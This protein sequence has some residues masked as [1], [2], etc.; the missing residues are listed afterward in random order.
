MG[1]TA[2]CGNNR[3]EVTA[4]NVVGVARFSATALPL[5]ADQ[6]NVGSGNDQRV[7]T[8]GVAP[9]P[10]SAWVSDSNNPIEGVPVTF[11]VREGGG[12]VNGLES[13][14]VPTRATGHA[15]VT[16]TA[17]PD[18]GINRVE[19][20][21]AGNRG[22][23]AVFTTYGIA[24][25][26]S[27]P[28]SFRGLVLDNSNRTIGRVKVTLKFGTTLVGPRLTNDEGQ[29]EFTDL[30]NDGAVH[31][32]VEG[33]T[34][35]KLG[36]QPIPAGMRFPSL[37]YD[38]AI[39]PNAENTLGKPIL[40][41]PLL[42]ENSVMWDGQSDV[43]LTCAGL[44]G[45]RFKVKAG[46]MTLENGSH[47]TPTAPVRLS[48]NQVHHDDVPMPMPNGVAPP[49]AWTFQPASATF[50]PPVEI[51]YP[52]MSAL[53][54]GAT[55]Y[56]LTFNHDLGE[57]E[58][59]APGRV[60]EDG[61][62]IV[63]EPGA[64][65]RL[66][67]WGCNC[68]PYSFNGSA[69]CCEPTS[70]GCGP[71]GNPLLSFLI[72]D[73]LVSQLG[74]VYC[75]TPACDNH[76]YCWGSCST[77]PGHKDACDQDILLDM[78]EICEQMFFPFECRLASYAYYT[79]VSRF[80]SG[81]YA[82][83]QSQL[84]KAGCC[85]G[86][87]G[88]AGEGGS[89]PSPPFPDA[90]QDGLP[91]DWEVTH[92]LSPE[93]PTD[94]FQDQDFDGLI[95]LMEFATQ[96]DPRAQ[97]SD[98]DG[99]MDGAQVAAAQ[100][101][102]KVVPDETWTYSLS[103][104]S[105]E[106][107]GSGMFTFLNVNVVDLEADLVSDDPQRIVGTGV[108][109]GKTY[110][111]VSPPIY[112]RAG[113]TSQIAP[114]T[115][116]AT[117]PLV[118]S[119]IVL[120]ASSNAL[121]IGAMMPLTTRALQS[122]G[123]VV[124]V[125][126]A[127]SFT[128]YRTSN[129]ALATVS[130][131]GVVTGIGTGRVFIT[132]KN[133][134]A[135]AVRQID[136]VA[137]AF[138]TIVTGTVQLPSGA[139]A[140]GASLT[141]SLGGKVTTSA[142]G[143]YELPL[144]V[145]TGQSSIVISAAVEV[146]G[147][148]FTGSSSVTSL[149]AGGFTEAGILTLSEVSSSVN[150]WVG[151]G[152][153]GDWFDVRNWS[154]S[155]VPGSNDDVVIP[156]SAEAVVLQADTTMR[157]LDCSADL[158]LQSGTVRVTTTANIT[159]LLRIQGGAAAG[160]TWTV[161]QAALVGANPGNRLSELTW[162]GDLALNASDASLRI[163]DVKLNGTATL[164]GSRS[165]LRFEGTQTFSSGTIVF[166]E[167][168]VSLE[169]WSEGTLTLGTEV[170][171]R[172]TTAQIGV[173][174]A[175]M[176]LVNQ[177]TIDC[178]I[179]GRAF[180]IGRW[181]SGSLLNS[182]TIQA[183]AGSSI[184]IGCPLSNS[185]SISVPSGRLGLGTLVSNTGI[186]S[187][188]SG[189][190]DLSGNYTTSQLDE[191]LLG[192]ECLLRLRG[193]L[194][195]SGNSWTLSHE[196]ILLEGTISGGTVNVVDGGLLLTADGSCRVADVTWNGDLVVYGRLY[197]KDVKLNGT[198]T[199]L[200]FGP[201]L[202]FEGTQ[203]FSSG[204][205]VFGE[206]ALNASLE[207]W[208]EGTLTLGTEVTVRG[209]YG[210]IG[211]VGSAMAL[212]NQGTIDCDVKGGV[213]EIGRMDSGSLSNSGTIQAAAGSA[214]RIRCPLSNS[215]SISVTAGRLGL[216]TLVSNTGS[217]SLG[218]GTLEINGAFTTNSLD[219]M[220]GAINLGNGVA[221]E[222]A[223]D[224][225]NSGNSWS[226]SRALTLNGGT[227]SGGTVNV[228]AGGSL[229]ITRNTNNRLVNATWNGDL[230]LSEYGAFLRIKD[231]ELNGT[232]TLSGADALLMFEGTQTFPSGTIVF[233]SPRTG[234]GSAIGMF[235]EGTLTLGPSVTVRGGWGGIGCLQSPTCDSRVG[236]A[237]AL[238]NRGR[239]ESTVPGQSLYIGTSDLSDGHSFANE[240]GGVVRA[241]A[242]ATVEI[243]SNWSNAGTLST[244]AGT[245][246]LRGSVATA[247]L[248]T[249]TIA[250][251]GAIR[252]GATLD[253]SNATFNLTQP[254][255]MDGGTISGGT[256]NVAAGG[257]L[258]ITSNTNNRLVNATWNGDLALSAPSARLRIKDV[259][260]NGT[261]TL[262]GASARLMFEGTQV[263]RKGT[264]LFGYTGSLCKPS[265]EMFT[266][267]TLTL[268]PSVIV[269]GGNG[270]LGFSDCF[271]TGSSLAL[272]NQGTIES[273][274]AGQS[275]YIGGSYQF[276]WSFTNGP[277][278]IVRALANTTV[279]IDTNWTNY[280][281]ASNSIVGGGLEAGAGALIL[282]R[283][284]HSG[285]PVH[286]VSAGASILV[287]G[288]G[289]RIF[290][291]SNHDLLASIN[292]VG[293]GCTLALD[294]GRDLAITPGG[295]TLVNNGT[296]SLGVGSDLDIVGG[297]QQAP[298][299]ELGVSF[300]APTDSP[301]Q[302][303]GPAQLAGLIRVLHGGGFSLQ[304][305][306]K[307]Q[308]LAASA[309][310]GAFD[311]AVTPIGDLNATPSPILYGPGGVVRYNYVSGF[312][313]L[314]DGS[315]RAPSGVAAASD[316]LP[317][318]NLVLTA[319]ESLAVGD[320]L[321]EFDALRVPAG[322]RLSVESGGQL[323]V[324]QLEI[325]PGAEFEWLGGTIEIAGGSWRHPEAI[326]IGCHDAALLLL[327][328]RAEIHA[329]RVEVC[330]LGA[331]RG[332]GRIH[333][334]VESWG[335]IGPLDAGLALE[336]TLVQHEFGLLQFTR[337]DEPSDGLRLPPAIRVRGAA[338]LDGFVSFGWID[339][340]TDNPLALWRQPCGIAFDALTS[341]R[342]RGALRPLKRL[343]CEVDFAP[344]FEGDRLRI[345][346]P[347]SPGC[348]DLDGDGVVTS[349]DLNAL[350]DLWGPC[351]AGCCRGDIA[352]L[353]GDGIVDGDDLAALAEQIGKE[354]QP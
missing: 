159:G 209:S 225:D 218:S 215:G 51:E 309:L 165:A 258:A 195:N 238:V 96:N 171:V 45:L 16:F 129:S 120:T 56:F 211:V 232:A 250:N 301:L 272:V 334:P 91:D 23:P 212:V 339:P 338:T 111:A 279:D 190:L 26:L 298:G 119:A 47:P 321:V 265:V 63:T 12:L 15:D 271:N 262:S 257:S 22:V 148:F 151:N 59:M 267:G 261:A 174:G 24:R 27:K 316:A 186:V 180:S 6:I 68:P 302:A 226:L 236:D 115:V 5:A 36:G 202:W 149:V 99:V 325:E 1:S 227:I 50:D 342:T 208:G 228:A 253:N 113:V 162:N 345:T 327:T 187:L 173:G 350:F 290:G 229:A 86:N 332:D 346:L 58:I 181:D 21:F 323:R 52:N 122:D 240:A 197:I 163:K 109:A 48:L 124:D 313:R 248:G 57:F 182:G 308:I 199:L 72:P 322:A 191:I 128:T 29:F 77:G 146:A 95:A 204:T 85:D 62:T 101:P 53:A 137:S 107:I 65:L 138:E 235:T 275:L 278:G 143:A 66:S 33:F 83:S 179:P 160:G 317:G 304:S 269:R 154:L 341:A 319:G 213:F 192:P 118:P 337:V 78:Y 251:G 295:G 198:A 112:L 217:V 185:D 285:E 4:S 246:A 270:R 2:G 216:G 284:L 127:A 201:A 172:G 351:R 221:V 306:D 84:R 353:G 233:D 40:L 60:S 150:T 352:P 244:D 326:E 170:T 114:L 75:F 102:R 311:A 132:A 134:S 335:E 64:G 344:E 35:N 88:L 268:G 126:P 214:I 144:V 93:D 37:G 273:T 196:M 108:V 252:F 207:M 329:P 103:G 130:Q 259:E 105:S 164:S 20:T 249:V 11:T 32:I 34:A 42:D 220:L 291:P 116:T 234:C 314:A 299:G 188:G 13:V 176:A 104:G 89:P 168:N 260:L 264:I 292:A 283:A 110:Y 281:S 297:Y 147:A 287:G 247:D 158:T 131:D 156:K 125:T 241:L 276:G 157:S 282:F 315:A 203:T 206:A 305:G 231:V 79:A 245:L 166:A 70:N 330:A 347:R 328:G 3:V 169:M 266:E 210:Q 155:R 254:W 100:P 230:A 320:G 141:S 289:A 87:G 256:V 293:A 161:A 263:F 194:D 41:P 80:G 67:G 189:A 145:P 310:D 340:A 133:N 167:I 14:T 307:P 205:I 348:P 354:V 106:G 9:L 17:G 177:G 280:D 44:D 73:C 97:D 223:G 333:A 303:S 121:A 46:S 8:G 243:R 39:V 136:I 224:I 184:D 38:T 219:S 90:D 286:A 142:E 193:T 183:V 31:V 92:G 25:D 178:D 139:P 74:E 7:E 19:A 274:V 94:G 43:T 343:A 349:A 140:A 81:A 300:A 175:A 28:T 117:P 288:P 69:S 49:F 55:A 200:G 296:I 324:R 336:E 30:A 98:G 294:G 76:D 277:T 318:L 123:T 153:P 82:D 222:F 152:N 331:L 237:M 242:G 135:T 18:A 312:R 54:P 71:S 61:S 10:L 255:T 239:I